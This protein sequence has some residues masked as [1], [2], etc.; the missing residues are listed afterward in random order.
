[1]TSG[2]R[3]ALQGLPFAQS[4]SDEVLE[5]LAAVAEFETVSRGARITAEGSPAAKVF[6]IVAGAAR[7]SQRGDDGRERT[8]A[9]LFANDLVGSLHGRDYLFGAKAVVDCRLLAF[10]AEAFE[11]LCQIYPRLHIAVLS[12]ASNEVAA[13]QDRLMILRRRSA[14]ARTA[15]FL[16]H[17]AD[18]GPGLDAQPRLW[19]P[20][21]K[22]DIADYLGLRLETLSRVLRDL[23]RDGIVRPDGRGYFYVADPAGLRARADAPD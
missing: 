6:V 19:V 10:D 5:A 18:R 14:G 4:L 3:S 21:R 1:M 22:K 13:L 20:M 23:G 7:I 9:F 2:V 11:R 16:V 8:V 12:R 17:L 15:A